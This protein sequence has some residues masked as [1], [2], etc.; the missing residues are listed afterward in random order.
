MLAIAITMRRGGGQ[1]CGRATVP[2]L[3][4]HYNSKAHAI[5]DN[6]DKKPYVGS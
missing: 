3:A 4:R 5:A 1:E 6:D 2:G